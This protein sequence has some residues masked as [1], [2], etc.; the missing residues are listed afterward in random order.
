MRLLEG[1][2]TPLSEPRDFRQQKLD[3]FWRFN[4]VRITG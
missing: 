2:V 3:S 1:V 4:S